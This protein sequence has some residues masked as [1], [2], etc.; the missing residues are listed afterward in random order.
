M[1]G[2]MP[3]TMDDLATAMIAAMERAGIS[4]L[5]REGRLEI[6]VQEGRALRPDLSDAALFALAEDL[7]D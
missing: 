7:C 5:C 4:G 3:P 1:S 2:K 6:A